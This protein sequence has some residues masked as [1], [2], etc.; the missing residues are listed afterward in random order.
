[1]NMSYCQFENTAKD[2]DA[3]LTSL[4]QLKQ[5]ESDHLSQTELEGAKSL[6]MTC[7]RV[8]ELLVNDS[9][10]NVSSGVDVTAEYMADEVHS[11]NEDIKENRKRCECCGEIFISEYEGQTLCGMN[12]GQEGCVDED[13][14]EFGPPMGT[15]DTDPV[16]ISPNAVDKI[17]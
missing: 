13:A 5:G 4:M 14:P 1:M 9:L 8:V 17:W 2:L 7:L 15:D 11:I 3:C 6:A 10:E 12:N 16:R